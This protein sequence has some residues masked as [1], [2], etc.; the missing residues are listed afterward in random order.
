MQQRRSSSTL[1][2]PAGATMAH[3]AAPPH[4]FP[5]GRFHRSLSSSSLSLASPSAAAAAAVPQPPARSTPRSSSFASSLRVGA[6]AGAGGGDLLKQVP[7]GSHGGPVNAAAYPLQ[8]ATA[9]TPPPEPTAAGPTMDAH[10]NV[11]RHQPTEAALPP[12]GGRTLPARSVSSLTSKRFDAVDPL[13]GASGSNTRQAAGTDDRRGVQEAAAANRV[14]TARADSNI[15]RPDLRRSQSTGATAG[16]W[17]A[18][19]GQFPRSSSSGTSAYQR[20]DGACVNH[21]AEAE[22]QA[23][24]KRPYPTAPPPQRLN[25]SAARSFSSLSSTKTDKE[26][27]SPFYSAPKR[28][29]S[30]VGKVALT[31]SDSAVDMN[32]QSNAQAQSTSERKRLRIVDESIEK[33]YHVI[34]QGDWAQA[35]VEEGDR[36]GVVGDFEPSDSCTINN[37]KNFL[38]IF[39]DILI[40]ATTIATSFDCMRRSVLQH[41]ARSASEPNKNLVSGRLI[42]L[43]FQMALLKRDFSGAHLLDTVE[44]ILSNSLEDL[45][46]IGETISSMREVL[47]DAIPLLRG[48]SETYMSTNPKLKEMILIP[49][50]RDEARYIMLKRNELARSLASVDTLP[51]PLGNSYACQRCFAAPTCM[52]YHKARESGTEQSFG[53]GA[54]FSA[55]TEHITEA[56]SKF[57][58]KWESAV[59]AEEKEAEKHKQEIWTVDSA[60]REAFGNSCIS[61]LQI[62]KRAPITTSQQF[63][64]RHEYQFS[65]PRGAAGTSMLDLNFGPGD[66][67]IVSTEPGKFAEAI[68]FVIDI[69]ANEITA[70][71][72]R[73]LD[74]VVARGARLFRVDKDELVFGFGSMRAN[75]VSLFLRQGSESLRALVVDLAPPRFDE[76]RCAGVGAQLQLNKC[77]L[78]AVRKVHSGMLIE[79][80][81]YAIILGMPGTG[82]TT[83]IAAIVQTLAA[84]GRSVLLTAYTHSA[85]DNVLMKLNDLQVDF[86][87]IGSHQRVHPSIRGKILDQHA[88]S[89]VEEYGHFCE[90]KLVVATTCL[91]IKHPIFSKRKFDY[92]IVDEASQLMLPVSLGPIR[93]ADVFVL[94]GD[95]DQLPPLVRSPIARAKGLDESLF[96]LLSTHH[97][98]AIATLSLQYRMCGDVMLLANELVY[99]GRLQCGDDAVARARLPVPRLHD[100]LAAL[101]DPD[102]DYYCMP[103]VTDSGICWVEDV[104]SPQRSVV[105]VDTDLAQAFETYQGENAVNHTEAFLVSKV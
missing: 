58:Q 30:E 73:S 3:G 86:M 24:R 11:L 21:P 28:L 19:P 55:E 9:A 16:G 88:F 83:T 103:C 22:A 2:P 80:L 52:V 38:I 65:R 101:H 100:A 67:I 48:W 10:P 39:P 94:V 5:V 87:R 43:L 92:C 7:F 69:K 20:V 4:S 105:F 8:R 81:D 59:S 75:L 12:S 90:S 29:A 68:G 64:D 46:S 26:N 37:D 82:K 41:R 95:H 50:L 70:S 77:Q 96:R 49:T 25:A 72:D 84:Q 71:L 104:L 14:A 17:T 31:H 56:H 74:A 61:H 53:I 89:T 13:R 66:P 99:S 15:T 40:P 54:L 27:I 47:V 32:E 33:E 6:S 36:V 45:Y 35:I 98:D 97:P 18:G 102:A 42:H 34:L 23:A 1:P 79:T 91:S 76:S 62:M 51:E 63:T 85:V 44:Q 93:L 78:D 57:F 60:T